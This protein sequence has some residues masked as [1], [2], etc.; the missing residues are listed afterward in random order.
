M[1]AKNLRILKQNKINVPDFIVVDSEKNVDLSFSKSDT[2]AVRSSFSL[3]DSDTHSFAGQFE[4]LLNVDRSGVE[5]A[6]RKVIE[7]AERVHADGHMRVIVQEMVDSDYAGMLFTANPLGLLNETVIVVGKGLGEMIVTDRMETTTY[8]YNHDD[9]L[10]YFEQQE[11]AAVLSEKHLKMLLETGRKIKDIFQKEMDI[12][13]AIKD[14]VVYILQ[15]R[16]ITTLSYKECIVLDN[17]NIV[18]SYPGISLPLTQSFVKEIYYEI[19]KSLVL[20]LSKDAGLVRQMDML[21]RDMVDV[22]NGRIYYRISNWYDVLRILPFSERI[23]AIWQEMLG[24]NHKDITFHI[25]HVP[26]RVKCNIVLSFFRYMRTTPK[27]MRALN[28]HFKTVYPMYIRQVR[29]E[30][31]VSGLFDLYGSM[32]DEILRE[33][34]ITL[35]NDMYAFIHTYFAKKRHA[36]EIADIKNLESM[37][38]VLALQKLVWTAKMHGMDSDLYSEERR[39]YIRRYGDRC[40]QE[41][42]LETKTYRTNPEMLDAYVAEAAFSK[43]RVSK[44][45]ILKKCV[46][47]GSSGGTLRKAKRAIANRELSRMNRSRLFGIVRMIMLK[48][49][50]ILV[51][52]G[53]L[54]AVE[55]VFYLFMDELKEGKPDYKELVEARKQEYAGYEQLPCY[56]RLL[57]ADKVFHKT[58]KTVSSNVLNK[59]DQLS[60]TV[61]SA[62]RVTG[63]VI[64]I[65]APD[66][67]MD[68]ADKIIVTKTTDPGWVF[69]IKPALGII[70]E[71]GSILSHTAIIT[72]ELKKP[73]VVNVKDA[74][75]ILRTGDIVELDAINGRIFIIKRK[76][77]TL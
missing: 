6:V 46:R 34:D 27:E 75:T 52:Q 66:Q 62:G 25:N 12:E 50:N 56:G 30:E 53:Q 38:P 65:D 29:A 20:R 74:T 18:E 8:Y 55:D 15:A 48:I 11:Q 64:I 54:E 69:L 10:Y 24:V 1:K 70:A 43:M 17:S 49:G 31:T 40:L 57:F 41:L 39:A 44:R 47:S 23:I 51:S 58:V 63:E 73:S 68:T 26:I 42:K 4:T 67:S 19:F 32:R 71:K 72:R 36:D 76:S 33:W 3:E 2:F 35:V 45:R 37:K 16:P 14:D 13:Y 22:C 7:S 61:S 77:E 5:A 60:G 9:D 21:L 59:P 28:A